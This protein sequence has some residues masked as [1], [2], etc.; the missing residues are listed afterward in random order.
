MYIG[1]LSFLLRLIELFTRCGWLLRS[2][3]LPYLLF[4]PQ[5][6]TYV[7]NMLKDTQKRAHIEQ[8]LK[9]HPE[10]SYQIC[11]AIEGR[12]LSAE[13]Q[14]QLFTADFFRVYGRN[15]SIPAAGC[16]ASHS[17]VYR[18]FLSSDEPYALILE[19]DAI[20]S[21]SLNLQ[22]L[23]DL[24]NVKEPRAVLLTPDFWYKKEGRIA[25]INSSYQ[26]YRVTTG[27]MASG[28]LINRSA[29]E[30]IQK[31]NTPV[32]YLA[33]DWTVFQR[34]GIEL[35]G[36]IPH[37]ISYPDGLGEV[38]KSIRQVP[39]SLYASCRAKAVSVYV[40]LLNLKKYLQGYSHSTKVWK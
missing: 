12:A 29:A 16:S 19:D 4:M 27:Y 21:A 18:Q 37:L 9:D 24:I 8:Q 39:K 40:L 5:T 20:L 23:L 36:V 35:Y 30:L 11:D 2:W 26:V 38:G 28:Y 17:L 22:P 7:I 13:E 3:C 25:D 6:K 32:R 14:K 15:A 34:E 33:D 10:L 31:L 1:H